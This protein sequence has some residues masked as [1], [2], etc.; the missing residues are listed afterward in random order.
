MNY[1]DM[2]PL[3]EQAEE[4]R[5]LY[6]TVFGTPEGKLVLME[7]LTECYYFDL[8]TT[9]DHEV[10]RNFATMIVH[11]LCPDNKEAIIDALFQN[12]EEE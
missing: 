12:K 8:P 1:W 11:T 7:L 9:R 4:K 3:D 10:L 6:R 2:L 5:R